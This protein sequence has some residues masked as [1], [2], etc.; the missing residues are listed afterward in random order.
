MQPLCAK[1]GS[2]SRFQPLKLSGLPQVRHGESVLW[3][4]RIEMRLWRNTILT[5]LSKRR[6]L[7]RLEA[8]LSNAQRRRPNAQLTGT[9]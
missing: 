1:A 5:R 2:E 3:R 6:T 8:E 4:T 7:R 9:T